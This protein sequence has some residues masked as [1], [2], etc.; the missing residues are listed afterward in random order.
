M[1]TERLNS[2]QLNARA[3]VDN[4]TGE[5]V[6]GIQLQI[7]QELSVTLGQQAHLLDGLDGSVQRSHLVNRHAD[8]LVEAVL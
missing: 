6:V 7:G 1:A 4:L 8:N 5:N 2:Q 3:L